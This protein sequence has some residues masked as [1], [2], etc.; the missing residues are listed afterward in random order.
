MIM[1]HA[2]YHLNSGAQKLLY[3]LD[4]PE[5]YSSEE[6]ELL[7]GNVK[8]VR[9]DRAYWDSLGGK[10]SKITLRQIINLQY[11]RKIQNSEWILHI[12]IDEF[13]H[14]PSLGFNDIFHL[15]PE[16]SEFRIEN[17]ERVLVHDEE[18]WIDGYLRVKTSDSKLLTKH[19]G[20]K[21]QF[22][23]LGMSNYFHGKSLVKNRSGIK[24][25][26]HGATHEDAQR[27]IIRY[28]LSRKNAVIIHY[29][30]ITPSHFASR[31][32][33]FLKDGRK[34]NIAEFQYQQNFRSY[35]FDESRRLGARHAIIKS[36]RELH[37][38]S[39]EQAAMRLEDGLYERIPQEFITRLTESA[40]DILNIN[41][42]WADKSFAQFHGLASG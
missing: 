14:R 33:E 27:E 21:A 2:R 30:C 16:I 19:Y 36:V 23:G 35:L 3:F 20:P 12:D 42:I 1:L 25:N 10:P 41:L 5:R 15:T 26:I 13:L 39:H 6:I 28:E 34:Y 29:A 32:L 38:C 17:V 8:V 7:S 40:L 24:Q 37:Y 22:F 11:A 18:T 4:M 9:C 31:Y